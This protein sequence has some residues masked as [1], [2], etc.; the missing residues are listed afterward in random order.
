MEQLLLRYAATAHGVEYAERVKNVEI[1]M[2][3]QVDF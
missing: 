1:D 3:H 2:V